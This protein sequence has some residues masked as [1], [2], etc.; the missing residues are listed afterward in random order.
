MQKEHSD[1]LKTAV[2]KSAGM[3]K[4]VE[5]LVDEG[6]YCVDI[7]QQVN[8]TIGLL[9]SINTKLLESHIKCCGSKKLLS[10]DP[11]EVDAFVKELV[12]TRDVSTR[13]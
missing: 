2:K 1:C 13:K 6:A 4:K 7:V 12:R 5:K 9:K 10:K 8:A 11:K 3:I